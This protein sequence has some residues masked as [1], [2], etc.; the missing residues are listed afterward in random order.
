MSFGHKGPAFLRN[1]SIFIP[2]PIFDFSQ[3]ADNYS[4][5][6]RIPHALT[7]FIIQVEQMCSA[8]SRCFIPTPYPNHK[9]S[10]DCPEIESIQRL[11]TLGFDK[12]W[13]NILDELHDLLIFW[14]ELIICG[15]GRAKSPASMICANSSWICNRKTAVNSSRVPL[16]QIFSKTVA[17]ASFYRL[18]S[19]QYRRTSGNISMGGSLSV[20]NI[21]MRGDRFVPS[22]HEPSSSWSQ[23]LLFSAVW[24][25]FK[26]LRME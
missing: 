13:V 10:D 8:V 11:S 6:A 17:E 3:P 18:T 9:H 24:P 14:E 26:T 15:L 2:H 20:K 21:L 5:T 1:F 4:C 12:M 23:D 7:I 19:S 22:S 25:G 16:F